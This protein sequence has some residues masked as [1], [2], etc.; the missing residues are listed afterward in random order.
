MADPILTIGDLEPLRPTV[1]I[2]RTAPDGA[3]QRWK[4]RHL[5]VLL[6]WSPVRFTYT[7][8]LYA[9]RSPAE[10]G[11]RSLQR[12][13]RM[14]EELAGLTGSEDDEALGRRYLRLLR[15]VVT[16]VLEAPADV[17]EGLAP[18]DLMR[19]I[20][21][22][23][24]AVTGRTPTSPAPR[25]TPPISDASSPGSIASTAPGTG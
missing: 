1:A 9:L 13:R 10:F 17:I 8:E 12:L 6:R 16:M 11:M 7:R 4:F 2:G 25:A 22:F 21:V 19:V 24:R 20:E 18:I 3:W 15:A 5:D 14:Q 23:P